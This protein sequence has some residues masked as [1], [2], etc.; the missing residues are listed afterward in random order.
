MNVAV[1]QTPPL[2]LPGLVLL[3]APARPF[4]S[5]PTSATSEHELVKR[6]QSGDRRSFEE[7]FRRHIDSV[8][9]RLTR[10][11]GPD[12]EREDLV[13]E[14]FLA[15]F[16]GLPGFRQDAAFSTWLFR[17]VV[18]VAY[19]HLRRSRRHPMEERLLDDHQLP[20]LP[21]VSPEAQAAMRQEIAEVFGLLERI[22][23]K[24]RIA[25]ILRVVEGLSL[26]E[27]G[28]LVEAK[29]AAVGQRVKHAQRELTE[30]LHKTRRNAQRR[31]T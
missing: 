29:P 22:K 19:S 11:I 21:G 17:I 6:A 1:V 20:Q 26:D 14:V 16:R 12:P 31:T 15:A 24:K 25:F 3:A 10:L 23:P 13:Q 9:G 30:L 2:S 4:V 28:T 27:I 5:P 18:R 8:Y 7:L